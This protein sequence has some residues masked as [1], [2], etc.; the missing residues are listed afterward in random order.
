MHVL[1]VD[2]REV[3]GISTVNVVAVLL[4]LENENADVRDETDV[5]EAPDLVC[6]ESIEN[7]AE[8]HL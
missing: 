2:V 7:Q 1:K 8:H 3:V 4:G 5:D 6:F